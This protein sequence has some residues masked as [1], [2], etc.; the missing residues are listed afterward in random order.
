M[1][2]VAIAGLA[3]TRR[4]WLATILVLSACSAVG[5]TQEVSSRYTAPLEGEALVEFEAGRAAADSGDWQGASSA[6]ARAVE[7]APY[8]LEAH[9][10]Y[11]RTIR[12]MRSEAYRGS[13]RADRDSLGR[14]WSGV[15]EAL[16]E[17]YRAWGEIDPENALFPYI[18][19][20]IYRDLD[21]TER[22]K[23]AALRAAELDPGFVPVWKHLGSVSE[24]LAE[25]EAARRYYERALE[26]EPGDLGV[27]RGL[28]P[29]VYQSGWRELADHGE[30][31]VAVLL[32]RGGGGDSVEASRHLMRIGMHA[33]DPEV[34][35]EYYRR[36]VEVA[37][38][39]PGVHEGLYR[40][41][42]QNRPEEAAGALRA[43]VELGVGT[44]SRT[45]Y[46][47]TTRYHRQMLLDLGRVLRQGGEPEAAAS[48][49]RDALA[50][51][52]EGRVA[53]E[54]DHEV[55]RKVQ[56]EMGLTYLELGDTARGSEELLAVLRERADTAAYGALVRL[57]EAQGG[58]A[59][60]ALRSVWE[61]RLAGARPAADFA[62][63]DIYGDT[64]RLSD[65]AGEVLLLS[66]WFPSC[67][68][69]RDEFPYLAD[70]TRRLAER[71]LR[72]VTINGVP[73][74][75]DDVKPIIEN[76]GYPMRALLTEDRDWALNNYRVSAY[77]TNFL[78][79]PDG[80]VVS[81]PVIRDRADQAE[82][83]RWIESYY[84]YLQL[85]G[86]RDRVAST[87]EVTR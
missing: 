79:G 87:M 23:A 59:G 52:E 64:V 39:E 16:A 80:R 20:L 32:A 14:V 8:S 15:L 31:L 75:N 42:L 47:W 49:L 77:P 28:M 37:P 10:A 11:L 55:R 51:T 30:R 84:D 1:V 36:A 58:S 74:Q 86:A 17:R 73:S 21:Q 82:V 9:E 81:K 62:L 12:R 61:R 67:G 45:R 22:S 63:A 50:L 18:Q 56:Y 41:L 6:Y 3:S 24:Y 57:V 85:T 83:E 40:I 5:G 13:R 54:L 43:A 68:P 70:L 19:A 72:V 53:T 25:Y 46:G 76:Y 26:L 29:V 35:V 7:L 44:V 78:I 2:E 65:F 27:L 60:D 33:P 69:C 34:K 4:V 38:Q 71:G 48:Y 66:F